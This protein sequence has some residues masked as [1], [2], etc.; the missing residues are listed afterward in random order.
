MDVLPACLSVYHL[1][2]WC[3]QRPEEDIG[4]E[5]T[6]SCELPGEK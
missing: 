1:C 2:A 6:D 3:P 5:V 4:F